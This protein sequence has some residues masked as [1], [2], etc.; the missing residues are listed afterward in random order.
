MW[1]TQGLCCGL[2][3]IWA[4]R[5]YKVLRCIET[6]VIYKMCCVIAVPSLKEVCARK[7]GISATRFA[8]VYS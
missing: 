5:F 1:L 6:L 3:Q 8:V 7:I 4:H 2:Q